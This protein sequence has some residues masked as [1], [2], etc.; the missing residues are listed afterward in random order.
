MSGSV[1]HVRDCAFRVGVHVS[2]CVSARPEQTLVPVLHECGITVSML[3][4][5]TTAL[6]RGRA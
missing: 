4:K 3:C 1:A 5:H 2:L 6:T